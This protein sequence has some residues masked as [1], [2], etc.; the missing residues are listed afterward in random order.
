MESFVFFDFLWIFRVWGV[1]IQIMDFLMGF[2]MFADGEIIASGI[3]PE[4]FPRRLP[5][6]MQQ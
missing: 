4:N 2:T 6:R 5:G 3:F 1:V